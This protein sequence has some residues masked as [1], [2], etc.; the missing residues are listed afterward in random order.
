MAVALRTAFSLMVIGVAILAAVALR[1]WRDYYWSM[2]GGA[3]V[4]WGIGIL[5]AVAFL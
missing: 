2:T 4:G 3:F 5:L 1:G